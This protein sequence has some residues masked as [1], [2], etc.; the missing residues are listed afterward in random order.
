MTI[1]LVRIVVPTCLA[2][3]SSADADL[4]ASNKRTNLIIVLTDDQDT[5]TFAGTNRQPV[6]Q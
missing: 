1:R 2:A 3:S 6:E 5:R 4:P